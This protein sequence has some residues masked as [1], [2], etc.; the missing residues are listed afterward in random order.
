MVH[1]IN[2]ETEHEISQNLELVSHINKYGKNEEKINHIT[3]F[4]MFTRPAA[5]A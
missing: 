1:R 5:A 3:D 4:K 2:T